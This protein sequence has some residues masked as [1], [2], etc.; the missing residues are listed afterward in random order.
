MQSRL[1]MIN[2]IEMYYPLVIIFLTDAVNLY[3]IKHI[4]MHFKLVKSNKVGD[5]TILTLALIGHLQTPSL[6]F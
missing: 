4:F 3:Q 2:T 6:S 5:G 1:H